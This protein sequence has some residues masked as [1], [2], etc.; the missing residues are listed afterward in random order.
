MILAAV[1]AECQDLVGAR[2][3]QALPA[4]PG[5]LALV[6]RASGR[7]S[8]LLLSTHARLGR[9]HLVEA[10]EPAP[11][12]SFAQLVRSRLEGARLVAIAAVRF[13]RILVCSF[14]ALEGRYDMI[15][16]IMGRH[17]NLILCAEGTIVGALKQI[18]PDRS[19]VREVL[20]QQAYAR[21]PQPRP[22]PTTVT[23]ADLVGMAKRPAW[24]AVFEAVSGIGPALAW[25]ACLRAGA[26]PQEAMNPEG[27]SRVAAALHAI[28]GEV[29]A[30]RFDPVL[31]RGAD[32]APAAYAAFPLISLGHLRPERASMSRA[33]DTVVQGVALRVR[34]EEERAGL[35]AVVRQ[36]LE[37][38]RRTL[39]AV[40]EDAREAAGA[41]R[42]REH[43]ELILAY[44]SRIPPGAAVLEVPGYDGEPVTIPLEP[45][46][47]G[48]ENAQA[49]FRR[50]AKAVAARRRLPA[51][52][53]ELEAERAFL[54]AAATAIAQAEGADDLWEIEQDLVSAGVKKRGR[55]ARRPARLPQGAARGR[56]FALPGGGRAHVGRSARENDHLTFE[57]AGPDDLWL[58]AR[59]MPGAHVILTGVHGEP[60]SEAVVAAARIAAHYSDGRASTRVPV[61]VTERRFVRRVRGG[62]P[63]QVSY[64]HE[65]TLTVTPGLPQRRQ[66]PR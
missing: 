8:R 50:Y 49:C 44:L 45:S 30:A 48:V 58:H 39:A 61:V 4:G 3:Q 10:V 7:T 33:V 9:A 36:A 14:E 26:D 19:R 52:Q 17:S 53:A 18:G 35:A 37:R 57:V 28:G 43:G 25:E 16:E 41:E 12:S 59:G 47:S 21:P 11:P 22:V 24:R 1:V 5:D 42:L 27:A 66:D 62:R 31:Y 63:G 32:G 51:R 46:R 40:A 6:L 2:L 13:E 54:E 55:P 29:E 23:E 38:V 20:P 60:A 64:S 15:A 34:L 56:A 65:R